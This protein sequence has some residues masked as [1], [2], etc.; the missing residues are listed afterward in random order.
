MAYLKNNYDAVIIK[1]RNTHT[2]VFDPKCILGRVVHVHKST[3]A[4]NPLREQEFWYNI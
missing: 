4:H 1:N 3:L 2:Q